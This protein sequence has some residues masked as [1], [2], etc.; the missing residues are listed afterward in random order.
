[1]HKPVVSIIT[2]SFNAVSTIENTIL[3]VLSLK[4]EYV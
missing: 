1:M 4:D 3:S 2:V